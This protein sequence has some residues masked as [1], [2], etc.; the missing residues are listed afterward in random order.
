MTVE[1]R[2]EQVD[3]RIRRTNKRLTMALTMMVVAAITTQSSACGDDPAGPSTNCD[4][5]DV[6][7]L[8]GRNL[9]K[10]YL[11]PADLEGADLTGA[12]LEGAYLRGTK[13]PDA[14]LGFVNLK[15]V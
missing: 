15:H 13:L 7:A 8:A 10:C 6:G 2:L 11:W 3:Q 4:V 9:S 5:S 12:N 14:N 1:Q